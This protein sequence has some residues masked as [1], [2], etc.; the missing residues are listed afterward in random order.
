MEAPILIPPNWQL[1]CHVHTNASLL[2]IGVMLVD[3]PIGKYDQF[4]V[5][6]SRLLN[7]AKK[8]Y[9]TT[10][11]K[12]LTMVYALHK[13]KHFLLGNKFVFYVD[14]MALVYLVNKPQVLGRITR[15]L[16]FLEYVFTIVYKPGKTHIIANALSRLL[17]NSKPLGVLDQS[18]DVLLFFVKPIWM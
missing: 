18:V 5:Y 15:W 8:I 3:N 6:A 14:H 2:A 10:K 17:D 1:E 12:A 9:N 11:R 4:I 16:L 13:F 7:K